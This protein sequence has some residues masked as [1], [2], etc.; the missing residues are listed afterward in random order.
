MRIGI[1]T[2]PLRYNYGGLL[3]AWALQTVLR[4][5]GHDVVT[6]DPCPYLTLSHSKKPFAYVK[7]TIKKILGQ[8]VTI[9]R[10]EIINKE[11][12]LKIQNLKPFIDANI[13]RMEYAKVTDIK[14]GDFDVLVAGSDQVWRP[15]YNR[16][17]GRT[18]ENAFFDFAHQWKNVKRVAYAASFGTDEWEFTNEQTIRCAVLAKQFSAISIREQSGVTLCKERLGVSATQVLDPTLLLD[19]KDY[20]TLIDECEFTHSPSGNLLCYILDE[21]EQTTKIIDYIS[22]EK[23]LIPFRANSRVTDKNAN[24]LEKIQPPIEQWLRN[25]KESEFVIT[26]SFHACVFSII[27]EKP[28]VVVGNEKRG[29]SRYESLLAMLSMNNHL[30]RSVEDF[31]STCPYSIDK[32][33]YQR[34]NDLKGFSLKYLVDSLNTNNCL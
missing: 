25:F 34:I 9:K 29:L 11:Y 30:I 33:R 1:Y 18:I 17:Y 15:K 12:N 16:S 24:I 20:E 14:E 26:D 13:R 23:G 27:F 32:E 4:R 19:K 6:F 2:Q 22:K 21:T 5:M 7:R 31:V 28:F 3:Q 10:E 8:N